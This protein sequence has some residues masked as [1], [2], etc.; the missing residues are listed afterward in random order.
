MSSEREIRGYLTEAARTVVREFRDASASDEALTQALAHFGEHV[1]TLAVHVMQVRER[2]E[3]TP[4]CEECVL[5]GHAGGL[6]DFPWRKA[7]PGEPC[8]A[9]DH[10]RHS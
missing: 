2:V 7:K 5:Q 8:G 1:A 6:P 10:G 3:I 4:L 9:A